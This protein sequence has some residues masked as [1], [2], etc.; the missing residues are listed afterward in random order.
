VLERLRRVPGNG[1]CADCGAASPEWAS[2]NLGVLLCIECG[3]THR[4]LGVH[5]SKVRAPPAA[6]CADGSQRGMGSSLPPHRKI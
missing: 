4:Q 1:A 5:V 3:G 2:L 6:C